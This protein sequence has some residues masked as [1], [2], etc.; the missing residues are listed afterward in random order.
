[1]AQVIGLASII[2]AFLAAMAFSNVKDRYKLTE[3]VRPI[4]V[5]LVPFFF[6]V[7]GA[8]VDLTVFFGSGD[9]I[10]LVLL[11]VVITLLAIMGKYF[12]CGLGARSLGA[13]SRRIIG[14]GMVPRGEVGIIIAAIGLGMGI[15]DDSLFSVIVLMAIITTLMAPPLLKWAYSISSEDVSN[16][17]ASGSKG[18]PG[19]AVPDRPV[20]GSQSKKGPSLGKGKMNG[21]GKGKGWELFDGKETVDGTKVG[22]RLGGK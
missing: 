14:I 17:K 7:T 2:G 15:L 4:S 18:I 5:L 16:P 6:V 19:K 10:Y 9:A 21:K 3:N 12:G 8:K 11:T 22:R 1:M 13:R 20:P